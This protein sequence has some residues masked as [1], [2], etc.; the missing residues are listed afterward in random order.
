[1]LL[2]S[3][4]RA[5]VWGVFCADGCECEDL[6]SLHACEELANAKAASLKVDP[7]MFGKLGRYGRMG[8]VSVRSVEVHGEL[9]ARQVFYTPPQGAH[10]EERR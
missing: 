10:R 4:G 8:F 2:T 9:V 5:F 7:E 6:H 1:M 3:D